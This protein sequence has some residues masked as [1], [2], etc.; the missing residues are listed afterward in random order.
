V[1]PIIGRVETNGENVQFN[2]ALCEYQDYLGISA[3]GHIRLGRAG[4]EG[5]RL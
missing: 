3:S 5:N 2:E 4:A 1:T